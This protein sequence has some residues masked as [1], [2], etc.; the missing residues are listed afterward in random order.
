MVR[1]FR[2]PLVGQ[3]RLERTPHLIQRQLLTLVV[4]DRDVVAAG[5]GC[6]D[7]DP[8]QISANR[9][10]RIALDIDGERLPGAQ[11][12]HKGVKLRRVI[13]RDPRV[14]QRRHLRRGKR[15]LILDIPGV[16]EAVN[17]GAELQLAEEF[18]DLGAIEAPLALGEIEFDVE[19]A[20]IVVSSLAAMAVRKPPS[21]SA[22][23]ARGG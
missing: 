2:Q 10:E 16:R 8:N 7:G 11:L 19:I 18:D 13:N 20:G 22:L 5:R 3:E 6:G 12:G 21:S 4:R 15:G 17:Q 14:F 23:R 1:V 9:V